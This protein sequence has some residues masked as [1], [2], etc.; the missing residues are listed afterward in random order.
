MIQGIGTTSTVT[1]TPTEPTDSLGKDV[2][3]NLLVTQLKHQDP[4]EPMEGTEFVT[5]LAQFSELDELRELTGGQEDLQGYMASLNN[6]AAVSLLG[7]EVEFAGDRVTHVEGTSTGIEFSL[8]TEAAQ[9]AILVYDAQG[10]LVQTLTK[11]AMG[12]GNQTAV[13]DGAD[14]SG[15]P[16]PSGTYRF[17]V[18]ATDAMGGNIPVALIQRGSVQEVAFQDGVPMVRIDDRWVSLSEVQGIR[19]PSSG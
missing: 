2:F 5:Q 1:E 16:L 8:P 11:G 6:F 19:M 17:E 4:L 15:Q 3:L 18:L 10:R 9:A 14:Q 7:K 13:W 12:T